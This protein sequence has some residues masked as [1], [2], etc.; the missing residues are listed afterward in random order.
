MDKD[1]KNR[2]FLTLIVLFLL[3][4]VIGI[5]VYEFLGKKKENNNKLNVS[6][7]ELYASDYELIK[8]GDFFLGVKDNKVH[9]VLSDEGKELY[10]DE[11][12]ASYQSIF[13]SRNGSFLLY[14]NRNNVLATMLY[15]EENNSF[16]NI[17]TIDKVNYAKPIIYD[18]KDKKYVLGFC[19]ND[20][21]NLYL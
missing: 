14:D 11:N 8:Q 18:G 17:Q 3:F 19:S 21:D 2:I 6:I 16:I 10:R 4:L 20:E 1:R 15:D 7:V 9:L 13:E 5:G 12:G